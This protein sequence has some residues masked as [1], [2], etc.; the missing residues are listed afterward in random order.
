MRLFHGSTEIVQFPTILDTQ[1]LLDFGKGF[2]TTTNKDQAEKWALIKRNRLSIDVKSYVS[3]YELDDCFL[4]D[5]RY[6]VIVFNL[7]NEEWLDFVVNKR[8]E[9][10]CHFFDIVMGAVANDT[11]YK[12]LSLYETGILSKQETIIRLKV[13]TLYDQLS[14]HNIGIMNEIKFINSYEII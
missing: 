8:K 6:K 10:K 12:T 11:L 14:F 3:E 7:A 1:C 2:Y 4:Q 13:H 5:G 9:D